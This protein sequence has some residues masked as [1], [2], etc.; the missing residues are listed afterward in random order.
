MKLVILL[1]LICCLNNIECCSKIE[2]F[3]TEFMFQMFDE[4]NMWCQKFEKVYDSFRE[5]FHRFE[6]WLENI[7]KIKSHNANPIH[8]YRFGPNQFTDLTSEEFKLL[9][10]KKY[11][12][13]TNIDPICKPMTSTKHDLPL[14]VDWRTM[15]AV[16]PVKDQGQCGSCWAFS[17]TGALE[18]VCSINNKMLY[19]LSEQNLV[20]CSNEYGNEGCNGGI[21]EN[22]FTYIIQKG[23]LCNESSYA[24]TG[25]DGLC[26]SENC[27]KY[28]PI[29]ECFMVTPN[30]ELMLQEAV[31][32]QPVSVAIEADQSIFQFYQSGVITDSTDKKCGTTLDH[33]VLIV[34]YGTENNLDYWL[35]KNSWGT[36]WGDIGY[37]KVGRSKNTTFAGVCGIAMDPSYPSFGILN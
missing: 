21:M 6:I 30:N 7:I 32:K 22:A 26:M 2:H 15:N 35:V 4:F 16:T 23:G 29:T 25:K 17:T 1:S 14:E 37:V 18:G 31:S 19:S 5:R 9:I 34:G 20:D 3:E 28:C 27:N 24:Y 33:G 10:S 36:T 11:K 8:T 13:K 12:N